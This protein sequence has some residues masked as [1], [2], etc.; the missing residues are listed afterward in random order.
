MTT[1]IPLV[2]GGVALVDDVDSVLFEEEDDESSD[3]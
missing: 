2:N 3:E 1:E